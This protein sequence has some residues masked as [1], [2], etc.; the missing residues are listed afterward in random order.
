M[1][2][3]IFTR[4]RNAFVIVD[5]AQRTT[6]RET[7]SASAP[8][9]ASSTSASTSTSDSGPCVFSGGL[10]NLQLF[11]HLFMTAGNVSQW[12]LLFIAYLE[13]CDLASPVILIKGSLSVSFIAYPYTTLQ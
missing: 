11:F 3:K 13:L 8:S 1:I 4:Y 5:V 10:Y 12:L 2:L 7:A 9:F 6:N